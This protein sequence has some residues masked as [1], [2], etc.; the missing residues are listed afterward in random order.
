MC[1][2]EQKIKHFFTAII[3]N[4]LNIYTILTVSPG[5]KGF[6]GASTP[7]DT[8]NPKCGVFFIVTRN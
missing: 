8:L 4:Y 6:P 1:Q 2:T 7:P 5:R 3:T